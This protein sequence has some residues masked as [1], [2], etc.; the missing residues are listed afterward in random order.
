MA[1]VKE[2]PIAFVITKEKKIKTKTGD[3]FSIYQGTLNIGD[4]WYNVET[5]HTKKG[6]LITSI[7]KQ[8][9]KNEN[10]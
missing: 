3:F 1:Y 10:N 8:R 7:Y 4:K 6:D 9:P 2:E 5:R